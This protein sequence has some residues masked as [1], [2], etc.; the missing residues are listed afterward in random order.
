MRAAEQERDPFTELW[1]ENEPTSVKPGRVQGSA[2]MSAAA[3][4]FPI[5]QDFHDLKA[6]EGLG[7]Q[8]VRDIWANVG[9]FHLNGWVHVLIALGAWQQPQEAICDRSDAPWASAARRPSPA[10][11]RKAL[12]RQCLGAEYVSAQ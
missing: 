12:Q 7:Q 9:A 2:I 3:D 11:R 1:G 5:E 4:R 6:V 10:D 8:Q